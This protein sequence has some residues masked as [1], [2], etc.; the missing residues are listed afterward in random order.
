MIGFLFATAINIAMCV[1]NAVHIGFG[2]VK[3]WMYT[4]LYQI[5][6]FT[7]MWT[8]FVLSYLFYG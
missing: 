2:V 5:L 3:W 7:E 6:C 1:L 8:I 4:S